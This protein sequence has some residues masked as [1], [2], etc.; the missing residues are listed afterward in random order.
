VKSC[1]ECSNEIRTA[2]KRGEFLETAGELIAFH[3]LCH[4]ELMVK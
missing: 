4:M 1:S 2:T 3:G